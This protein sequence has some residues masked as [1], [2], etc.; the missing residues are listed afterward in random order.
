MLLFRI[1]LTIYT[2]YT[3]TLYIRRINKVNIQME[4]PLVPAFVLNAG[5]S[6]KIVAPETRNVY[7]PKNYGILA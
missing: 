3:R 2:W 5:L 7:S 1:P 6:P 4:L